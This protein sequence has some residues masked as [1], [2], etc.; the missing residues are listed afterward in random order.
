M[1]PICKSRQSFSSIKVDVEDNG[2]AVL[3]IDRPQAL[4]A[5]NTKARRLPACLHASLVFC[6][7]LQPACQAPPL[8]SSPRRVPARP[9]LPM[10]LLLKRR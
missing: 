9:L 7:H 4:N 1:P 3:T 2:V 10:L 6:A 5:L 8:P